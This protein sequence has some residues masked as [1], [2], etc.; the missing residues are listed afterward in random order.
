MKF[1]FRLLSIVLT[2]FSL[3]QN[4][5]A[6]ETGFYIRVGEAQ[7]KKSLVALPE[8]QYVGSPAAAPQYQKIGAELFKVIENNLA[9]TDYFTFAKPTSFLEDPLKTA[10]TPAPDTPN[11]FTY[12]KWKA[13]G[14]DILIRVSYT[15]AGDNVSLDTY[16]YL[17]S[18]GQ[19]ILGKKYTTKFSNLHRAAHIFTNDLIKA[20]TGKDSIFL[21]KIVVSARKQGAKFKEIN[22]MDWDGFNRQQVTNH[23]SISLSPNWSPEG[24]KI[25]Y[26]AFVK[27]AGPKSLRNPDMLM[28]DL[29]TNQRWLISFRRGLNSGG[30]FHPD[31]KSLFLT[32]SES[33]NSDIYQLDLEGNIK[34]R[35]TAGPS[36]A[37][38]VEPAPS[39]DGSKL[40]FS[41][42]RSGHPMIWVMNTDGSNVH[43]VTYAGVYNSS[44]AWSPDGKRIAFAGFEKDH[45]DIFIMDADGLNIQRLTST[46]NS[47]SGK[48]SSNEDPVFSPDGRH[49]MFTSDRTDTNQIY[50][51]NVDGNNERR[52]TFDRDSYFKP[53]W[54]K[55]FDTSVSV[56]VPEK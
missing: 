14:V 41:S 46:K 13:I 50:I 37:L 10:P 2:L 15:I 48:W 1:F 9:V 43:R 38:N 40:A 34:R 31:G 45:Y 20:L 23:N 26:T 5:L 24:T 8:L 53:R 7:V 16:S 35:L 47:R 3:G 33:G 11:G 36:G 51:V 54:S 27:R 42:D 18:K 32:I 39:P 52:I 49:V 44:P 17:I 29:L 12:E 55:N 22:L 6:E 4:L 56:E 25:L 30:A 19:L 28:L 21:S